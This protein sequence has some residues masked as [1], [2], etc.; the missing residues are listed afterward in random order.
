MFW[1][2]QA[3]WAKRREKARQ[4]PQI[5]ENYESR[6]WR[7]RGLALR[8]RSMEVQKYRMESQRPTTN[9]N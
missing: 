2:V 4:L 6:E 3:M 7:E 5:Q 1:A 9:Q 8:A